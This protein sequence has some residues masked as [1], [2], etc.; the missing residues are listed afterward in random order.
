MRKHGALPAMLEENGGV[1]SRAAN[2]FAER[3][4][5]RNVGALPPNETRKGLVDGKRSRQEPRARSGKEERKKFLARA[6]AAQ[7]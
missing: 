1:A 5:S 2:S 4:G 6:R 7:K 3:R